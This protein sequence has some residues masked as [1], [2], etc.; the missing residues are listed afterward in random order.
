MPPLAPSMELSGGPQ[1]YRVIPREGLYVPPELRYRREDVA[2]MPAFDIAVTHESMFNSAPSS[3]PKVVSQR[4]YQI[5]HENGWE[6]NW[7]PVRL[8]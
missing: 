1:G 4:F 8:E 7:V 5:C 3:H 2:E 6:T